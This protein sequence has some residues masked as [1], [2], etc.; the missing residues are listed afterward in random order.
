M[1]NASLWPPALDHVHFDQMPSLQLQLGLVEGLERCG[2][3]GLGEQIR[4]ERSRRFP[5]SS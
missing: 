2:L 5:A 4:I 3:A 1:P